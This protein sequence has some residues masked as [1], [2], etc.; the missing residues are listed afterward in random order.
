MALTRCGR[1]A[2][3]F[4][5]KSA[6][7]RRERDSYYTILERTRKGALDVTPWQDWFLRCLRRAVNGSQEKPAR[8][9]EKARFW[10]GFAQASLSTRQV[11]VLNRLLYGF[12]GMLT[13]S[14]RAKPTKCSLDTAYRE[15]LDLVE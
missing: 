1:S 6:Q 3:R 9:L 13:T 12:K 7:I 11:K 4:Y 2:Q 14:K 5:S 10:D 8:V 15:I